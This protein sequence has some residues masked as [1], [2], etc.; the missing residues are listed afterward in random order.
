LNSKCLTL[1]EENQKL[2]EQL[3]KACNGEKIEPVLKKQKLNT[4]NSLPK[5]LPLPPLQQ[6]PF[7]TTQFWNGFFSGGNSQ[8]TTNNQQIGT[9][10]KVVLFIALFCVALFLVKPEQNG[11]DEK[12]EHKNIGRIIQQAKETINSNEGL[13]KEV[14]SLYAILESLGK[15]EYSSK[16]QESIG[17][18][19]LKFDT[20][21]ENVTFSFPKIKEE[22]VNEITVSKSLF[23]E[24]CSK[25]TE[26]ETK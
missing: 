22:E 12:I 26:V 2:R 10:P 21:S 15:D 13:P 16:I 23:S 17:K 1:E 11:F 6:M 19:K 7:L 8:T 14:R 9:T 20:K 18:I 4:G 24:I 25:L 3:Q 5:K